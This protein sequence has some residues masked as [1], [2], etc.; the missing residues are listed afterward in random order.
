MEFHNTD[1]KKPNFDHLK[2]RFQKPTTKAT[3]E[4]G[5][6]VERFVTRL[7]ASRERSGYKPLPPGFY[8]SKM[9]HIATDE[10][11]AFYKRCEEAKS[12]SALWWWTCAPKK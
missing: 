5:E 6:L 8:G 9:S 10:L 1:T 11:Y 12:F 2:E 3:S 7:N 4:R